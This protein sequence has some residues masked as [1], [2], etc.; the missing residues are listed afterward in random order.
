MPDYAKLLTTGVGSW[1]G[2]ESACDRSGLFSEKY[3]TVPI[4]Q[5]LAARTGNRA[6]AEWKHP[7]LAPL[8]KGSGRRPE[9]DFVI[10]DRDEK[11]LAA[12]ESKWAGRP[13]PSTSGILWDLIRLELIAS[14]TGATCLFLLGG[15]RERISRIFADPL[16][17]DAN[18]KP[19]RK[20]LLRH[21]NNVLHSIALVPTV[22]SRVPM[23]KALFKNYQQFPFPEKIV[24]RR[25]LPFPPDPKRKHYQVYTWEVI[26]SMNSTNL[27]PSQLVGLLH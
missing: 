2:F 6:I 27:P 21:D 3:L 4:G 24:T 9:V 23:L 12:V 5:I 8:A 10:R 22:R 20:P 19:Y 11:I 18:S 26:P 1:L 15:T 16:F 17:S 25:T 13:M 7:V 14:E